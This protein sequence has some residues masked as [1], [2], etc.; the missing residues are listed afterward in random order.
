MLEDSEA[1][2][3]LFEGAIVTSVGG[4]SATVELLDG[5]PEDSL[6]VLGSGSEASVSAD[7][8]TVTI[9]ELEQQ[10][11]Q[12]TLRN[13]SM[14]SIGEPAPGNRSILM[15]FTSNGQMLL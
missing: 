10:A 12:A 3:V 5:Q 1:G 13:I 7:G 14:R 15:N 8:H 6:F 9:L 4:I 2:Q 11:M